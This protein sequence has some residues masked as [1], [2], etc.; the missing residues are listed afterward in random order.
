M[1]LLLQY[2][3]ITHTQLNGYFPDEQELISC[4]PDSER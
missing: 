4:P 1:I 3:V 2:I